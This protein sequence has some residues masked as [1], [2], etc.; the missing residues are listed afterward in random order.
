M[1]NSEKLNDHHVNFAHQLLHKQYPNIDGLGCTLLQSKPPVKKILNGLQ[2][3]FDRGDHWSSIHCEHHSV[4]IYDSVYSTV[5]EH[6]KQVILNLFDKS[7]TDIVQVSVNQQVGSKD[8]GLFAIAIATSLL[9]GDDVE[10]IKYR[11]HEMRSHLDSCFVVK[12]LT[13]FPS[14]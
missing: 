9:F 6:T 1:I 10:K 3:I 5:D 13:P 8:C 2:I 12:K 14:F 11:Q 4:H 7:K